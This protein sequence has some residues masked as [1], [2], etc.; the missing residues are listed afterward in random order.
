MNKNKIKFIEY[1]L[2]NKASYSTIGKILGITKQYVHHIAK[3]NT[4]V[5][6]QCLICPNEA[7]T[8]YCVE[9]RTQIKKLLTD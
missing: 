4:L 5:K 7:V 1:C 6:K 2:K 3:K 9:C 8:D